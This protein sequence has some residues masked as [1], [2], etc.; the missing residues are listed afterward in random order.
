MKSS[1]KFKRE[2]EKVKS[3]PR[4]VVIELFEHLADPSYYMKL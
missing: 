1:E 2:R 4:E 3:C